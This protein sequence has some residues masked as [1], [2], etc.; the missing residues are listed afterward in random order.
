MSGR[1]GM[2][3]IEVMVASVILT[4][5]LLGMGVFVSKFQH[6]SSADKVATFARAM[7]EQR[8]ELITGSGIATAVPYQSLASTY[9]ETSAS[10]AGDTSYHRTTVVLRDS[11]VVADY[12]TITVTVTPPGAQPAV[13]KTTIIAKY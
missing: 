4:G 2:T 6:S 3:L 5:A 8:L 12:E 7:V 1:R 13:A 9:D 11:T 10:V